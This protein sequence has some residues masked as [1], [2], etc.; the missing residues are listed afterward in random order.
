MGMVKKFDVYFCETKNHEKPCVIIS[1][2]EMNTLLPYVVMAPITK[3][4]RAFPC[5]IGVKLKGQMGQIALDLMRVCPKAK[6]V[7]K[8]GSLPENLKKEMQDIL[9][10][11]FNLK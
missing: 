10:E 8:A 9:K 6:L 4:Q 2:D 5:R 7:K 3:N 1:P 11:F